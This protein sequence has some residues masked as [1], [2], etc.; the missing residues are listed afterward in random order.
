VEGNI[1]NYRG[2]NMLL[3]IPKLFEKIVCDVATPI[4]RPSISGEQHDLL[5]VVL[6]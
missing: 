6:R 5:V 1:S 3:V 4:I 2:I